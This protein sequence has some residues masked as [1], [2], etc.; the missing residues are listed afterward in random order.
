MTSA[1]S[2]D[3]KTDPRARLRWVPFRFTGWSF[4]KNA[5]IAGIAS[6]LALLI[7]PGV[8]LMSYYTQLSHAASSGADSDYVQYI[9]SD[10]GD[11]M[12]VIVLVLAIMMGLLLLILSSLNYRYMHGKA[13]SDVFHALPITRTKLLLSRFVSVMAMSFLPALISLSA[14]ALAVALTPLHG[15]SAALFFK[16]VGALAVLCFACCAFTALLAVSTGSGF[17]MFAALLVTNIGWPVVCILFHSLCQ[18]KLTGYP[19]F[20]DMGQNE[21]SFLF[22]PFG[23]LLGVSFWGNGSATN[24]INDMGHTGGFFGLWILLGLAFL[25]AA[26]LL[27]KRRKSEAAGSPYAFGYL[28]MTLQVISI[29]VAG[30]AVGI[31]FGSG[32]VDNLSFYI[33]M[34]VGAVLGAVIPG[35]IF[36]RGFK[37][38]KKDLLV[39][40]CVFLTMLAVTGVISSGGLG[41]ETRV[42]ALSSIKSATLEL[43]SSS[44]YYNG[45]SGYHEYSSDAYSD[46]MRELPVLAAVLPQDGLELTSQGDLANLRALHQSVADWVKANHGKFA[47]GEY[48][49]L[50]SAGEPE[51]GAT[52]TFS[53]SYHMK[54]GGTVTRHYNILS[55]AFAAE[56]APLFSSPAYQQ[57]AYPALFDGTIEDYPTISCANLENKNAF[58]DLLSDST[59]AELAEA[60][61]R[62]LAVPKTADTLLQNKLYSI[63]LRTRSMNASKVVSLPVY[64]G[65]ANTLAFLERNG[66]REKLRNTYEHDENDQQPVLFIPASSLPMLDSYQGETTETLLSYLYAN[67]V[68]VGFVHNDA[69]AGRLS[70]SYDRC[71]S[72]RLAREVNGGDNAIAVLP[73]QEAYGSFLVANAA[74]PTDL[75]S[76]P[77]T[78]QQYSL[79]QYIL[80]N[81]SYG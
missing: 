17:D 29:I 16:T 43:H 33:F 10:M 9:Q 44:P 47:S 8:P 42:P 71:S 22:S 27:Y 74:W 73:D 26:L 5:L 52:L 6:I 35:A 51:Q 39:A 40:G 48:A 50:G 60:Y 61:K 65:S 37:K 32:S 15:L 75:P 23:R 49:A 19:G 58:T 66:Y 12:P 14:T 78:E 56:L 25:A 62:D 24:W 45:G 20:G 69:L 13:A 30:A 31:L 67:K 63:D 41:Y 59:L 18:S 54:T 38:V 3:K 21:I 76:E 2:S 64:A 70:K 77:L 72:L 68:P 4:R 81:K 1:T 79:C 57:A 7:S 34:A 36:A 28:P 80:N 55:N 53:F 11:M 46:D